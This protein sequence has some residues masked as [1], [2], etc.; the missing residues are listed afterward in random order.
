MALRFI[1]TDIEIDAPPEAVWA[2]LADLSTWPDWHP[3]VDGVGGALERG[4]RVVLR[5]SAPRGRTIAVRQTV[6]SIDDGV[7]FRLAGKLGVKGLLDNEHRFRVEP[8]GDGGTRFLHGQ[9]FRGFLVRMMI[10]RRGASTYEVFD[11]INRALKARV[12]GS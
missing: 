8:A 6:A 3:F 11:E 1:E 4:R 2:V 12:E 9:A 7:E 10:R 5:K